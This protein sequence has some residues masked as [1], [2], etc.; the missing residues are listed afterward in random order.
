[1]NYWPAET[2][3]PGRVPRAAAR[4]HRASCA[5]NGAEDGRDQLRRARLDGASQPRPLAAAAPVGDYG[6]GDPVWAFWPMGGAWLCQHLWEHYAVR[7]RRGVPARTRLPGDEGRGG[8][9]PRLADRRRRRASW[10][11]RRRRRRRTSSS[12]AR[13][14]GTPPSAGRRRWT[15]RSSAELFT[16]MHRGGG[17]ARTSTAV[18]RRD[19]KRRAR[20]LLPLPDRQPRRSCRSGRE[21]LRGCRPASTGTS[22]TCTGCIPGRQITARGTPELFA[23]AR[24]SLELRGDGG[25]AGRWPGRSTSGRGCSTATTRS[26]CSRNLLRLGRRPRRRASRRGGVYAEP[27]RRAS[28]VPDRRQLRRDRR[29]RRDAAAEPRRRDATCCRRCRRRGRTGACAA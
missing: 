8:V 17:G 4:L 25:P 5:V 26:R 22:R 2:D 16:N 7:R 14:A 12:L 21:D 15:W 20:R 27:V 13:R 3:E 28:A 23:A 6:H 9:L 24:R 19:L 1:M 29:H 18:S 10:S 11:R